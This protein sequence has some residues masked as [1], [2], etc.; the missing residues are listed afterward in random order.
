MR[1]EER[2]GLLN[3]LRTLGEVSFSKGHFPQ[4]KEEGFNFP[5]IELVT[6][7]P[8]AQGLEAHFERYLGR[9]N[10]FRAKAR[11]IALAEKKDEK[12]RY[13]IEVAP[14]EDVPYHEWEEV[15]DDYLRRLPHIVKGFRHSNPSKKRGR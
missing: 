4:R 11:F 10:G 1:D 2:A 12:F 3:Y 7:E 9:H 15:T 5:T 13:A 14:Y 6:T 8:I